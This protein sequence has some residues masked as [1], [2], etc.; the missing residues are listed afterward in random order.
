MAE[1]SIVVAGATIF[2]SEYNNLR[3]DVLATSLGHS[4]DG[5]DSNA[6]A[7][8]SVNTTQITD[9]NVTT[10]KIADKN[11]TQVKL[12]YATGSILLI[13]ADTERFTSNTSYTKLKEIQ[14][15]RGG[16]TRIDFDMHQSGGGT[17][18]ARIYVNGAAFGTEQTTGSAVYV[19]KSE[20]IS[21]LNANE[22][23]Q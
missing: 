21:G 13:S 4:H 3:K 6:L 17:A 5:A 8:N 10:S 23:V 18:Y 11:V 20:T 1:S 9:A 12:T 19:T 14:I 15:A 22:L 7:A 2:A 16:S